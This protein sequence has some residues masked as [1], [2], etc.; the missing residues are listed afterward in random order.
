MEKEVLFITSY[1]LFAFNMF[2]LARAL[3]QAWFSDKTMSQRGV[4][5]FK[6]LWAV[7]KGFLLAIITRRVYYRPHSENSLKFEFFYEQQLIWLGRGNKK[8]GG[9]I[10]L[11]SMAVMIISF[12]LG[13]FA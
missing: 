3:S 2:F 7:V 5:F 11:G 13:I 6:V 12:I 4:Q 1:V 8:R 10:L 9:F